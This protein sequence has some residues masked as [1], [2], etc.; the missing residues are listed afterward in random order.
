MISITFPG[1]FGSKWNS[2]AREIKEMN[3]RILGTFGADS[4]P[5]EFRPLA[6]LNVRTSSLSSPPP[7]GGTGFGSIHKPIR[8]SLASP[9]AAR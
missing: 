9:P 8:C 1:T 6:F 2:N 3:R 7:Q 4:R 5:G